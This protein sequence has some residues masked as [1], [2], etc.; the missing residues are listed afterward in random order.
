MSNSRRIRLVRVAACASAVA[1]VIATGTSTAWGQDAGAGAAG[2]RTFAPAGDAAQVRLFGA[3]TY[4]VSVDGGRSWSVD[5]P[6]ARQIR[7]RSRVFDPVAARGEADRA[8]GALRAGT[9]G[10]YVVQF[11][12]VPL[13]GQ[14][15][16]LRRMGARVGAYL[17]DFAYVLRM[18]PATD[19]DKARI[20]GGANF[21]ETAGG[22]R[23]QGVR[24]EVMDGGVRASHQE[25]RTRPPVLHTPNTGDTSHGSSTYGQIFAAGV[26]P[27][28]RGML[29][30]GQGIFAMNTVTDRLAH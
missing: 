4:Q 19:M 18:E 2:V 23:G 5:L 10:A 26:N 28:G 9:A 17:P 16:E 14:R 12:A 20:A 3:D 29:P 30:E 21:V 22:Y 27:M 24:G 7:L 13:D 8:P 6:Q 25:F 15:Q 11:A 1:V